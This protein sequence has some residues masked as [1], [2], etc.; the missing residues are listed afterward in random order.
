[1]RDAH[2]L[3]DPML[4]GMVLLVKLVLRVYLLGTTE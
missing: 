1:M 3:L 2:T 4:R